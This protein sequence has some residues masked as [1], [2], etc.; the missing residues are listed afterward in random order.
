MSEPCSMTLTC[1]EEVERI[2]Q[3]CRTYPSSF[4]SLLVLGNY[5]SGRVRVSGYE[6]YTGFVNMEEA[7]GNG[8]FHGNM[9]GLYSILALGKGS[10]K[11]ASVWRLHYGRTPLRESRSGINRLKWLRSQKCHE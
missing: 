10:R 9:L 8:D 2:H 11:S 1:V 4:N 5:D 3:G 6:L 7:G